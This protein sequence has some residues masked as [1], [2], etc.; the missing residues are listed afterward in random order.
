L[1]KGKEIK[2]KCPRCKKN[3]SRTHCLT[4]DIIKILKQ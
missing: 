1:I 3:T 2:Q 4:P